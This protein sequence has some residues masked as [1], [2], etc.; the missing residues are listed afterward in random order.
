MLRALLVMVAAT[1]VLLL[2]CGDDDDDDDVEATV[3][4]GGD[5]EAGDDD[6]ATPDEEEQLE[7]VYDLEDCPLDDQ[8]LCEFLVEVSNNLVAGDFQSIV[9]QRLEQE[10]SCAEVAIEA[11]PECESEDD[12]LTG[13]VTTSAQGEAQIL[14]ADDYSGYVQ[15]AIAPLPGEE[16]EQE[17]VGQ[18]EV[19]SVGQRVSAS[20]PP[21]EAATDL[22]ASTTALVEGAEEEIVIVVEVREV[23]GQLW[24][25]S[26]AADSLANFQD[27]GF[28][29]P[30]AD[31]SGNVQ[32]WGVG[33]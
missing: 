18:V 28:A 27:A 23:D 29:D 19:R 6:G 3:E 11:F 20:A 14:N 32:P 2:A 26:F 25:T 33:S 9:S 7:G 4:E 12:T 30:Y 24:T 31:L 8:V 1:A 13:Y 15:A 10:I 16:Q 22:L 21:E 5:G 17:E